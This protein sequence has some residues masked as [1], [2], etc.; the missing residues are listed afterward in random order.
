MTRAE[1]EFLYSDGMR[2]FRGIDLAGVNLTG[3][4][5]LNAKFS[6]AD[7]EGAVLR[8]ADL[9]NAV[10]AGANL[11]FAKLYRVVLASADFRDYSEYSRLGEEGR[12]T[13]RVP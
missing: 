9:T 5:L 3:V 1:L 11:Q 8:A 7:F 12:A 10:L 2:T 13:V 4:E 6:D